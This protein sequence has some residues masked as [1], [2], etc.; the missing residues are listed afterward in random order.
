MAANPTDPLA[1]A[2]ANEFDAQR[3]LLNGFAE[4][5][6][7]LVKALLA[8]RGIP[9]SSVAGRVKDR[10]SFLRKVVWRTK[11]YSTIAAVTD[12]VGIRVVTFF[13][14]DIDRVADLVESEF[15]IDRPNSVDKRRLDDLD[16][17][18]YQSLH[19]VVSLNESR[20]KLS[21]YARFAGLKAEI[22]IRTLLQHA[23]AEIEHDRGYKGG[24]FAPSEFQRRFS[25][26]AGLLE[27]AD[28]E[29]RRLRDDYESYYSAVKRKSPSELGKLRVDNLSVLFFAVN[30][31]D[32]RALEEKVAADL[33]GWRDT[34]LVSVSPEWWA[35]AVS[36]L[37][38]ARLRTIGDV[39][40]ALTEHSAR[41]AEI[42]K[43]I[44][45]GRSLVHIGECLNF[46]GFL[47]TARRLSRAEFE[48]SVREGMRDAGPEMTEH[49]RVLHEI[50]N[51]PV[52]S[53]Q[54][55]TTSEGGPPGTP[56]A[57]VG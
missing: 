45:H 12:L 22:Q 7:T 13:V 1:E 31:P 9:I 6:L 10:K 41:L 8:G 20:A 11:K 5:L 4:I 52:P 24:R 38:K 42:L 56:P 55:T 46:L 17:F 2:L 44:Q 51:G 32:V 14:D 43:V 21:E 34:E 18:G 50:A 25:S 36:G 23:W 16:S 30:S 48:A 28:E 37:R 33:G 57:T 35:T 19:F 3:E 54:A 49:C 15:A 39:H 27:V 40:E 29:F 26:L 47:V 53:N